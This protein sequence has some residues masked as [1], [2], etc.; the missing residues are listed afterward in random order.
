M[1]K[2]LLQEAHLLDGG[3][4]AMIIQLELPDSRVPELED[5]M[6]KTGLATRKDL[7]N[8]ALGLFKWAVRE[9]RA[10]RTIASVDEKNDRYKELSMPSL[11]R[12][13]KFPQ[14]TAF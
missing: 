4:A 13:E 5:L 3:D 12:A 8:D 10:G 11:D 9:R 6:E 1:L 7:L 14:Q 2:R